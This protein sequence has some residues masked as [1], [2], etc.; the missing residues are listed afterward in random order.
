MKHNVIAYNGY[1]KLGNQVGYS[2]YGTQCFREYQPVVRNPRTN[3]QLL[4]RAKLTLLTKLSLV[5]RPAA[6]WGFGDEAR[7]RKCSA[8]NFFTHANYANVTGSTADSVSIDPSKIVCAQGNLPGVI[9][10][11]TIGTSTPGTFTIT[12][13]DGQSLLPGASDEDNIYV[14]AYCPDAGNGVISAPAHRTDGATLSV[15]YPASWSGLEMH[16]YG[17][18]TGPVSNTQRMNYI[19]PTPSSNSEYIGHVELG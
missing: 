2:M 6:L 10:S 17:F 5:F 11:S 1:G 7:G 4:Q 3:A 9:F 8:V 19:P 13:T 18:V 16:V 15:R 14:F 12:V